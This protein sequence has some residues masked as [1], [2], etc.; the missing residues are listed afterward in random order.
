MHNFKQ[1][2]PL[3]LLTLLL[4]S[5]LD[6][7]DLRDFNREY[8]EEEITIAPP[9]E[10]AGEFNSNHSDKEEVIE[11]EEDYEEVIGEEIFKIV[12]RMPVYPGGEQELFKFLGQ[13]IK[14]PA[15]ARDAGISGRVFVTFVVE[16]DGSITGVRILRGIGGGCDEEAVRVVSMMPDWTPGVQKG[17]PVR[18]Q[19]NLPI[20]FN[21][22]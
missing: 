22:R 8:E 10:R 1:L 2:F 21:L 9:P 3:I 16:K 7:D 19:F 18:V 14:Y 13:N 5:C 4:P 20:F 12:E 17:K 11:I 15:M 6:A